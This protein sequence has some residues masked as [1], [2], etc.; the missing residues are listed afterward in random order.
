[1]NRKESYLIFI[2]FI[3]IILNFSTCNNLENSLDTEVKLDNL[4]AK[5]EDLKK[6]L[7]ILKNKLAKKE[8]EYKEE[9]NRHFEKTSELE[10]QNK[11]L[12]KTNQNLKGELSELKYLINKEI[13]NNLK[14]I[15]IIEKNKN[16]IESIIKPKY[17]LNIYNPLTLK[18]D[19]IVAGLTVEEKVIQT[20]EDINMCTYERIIFNGEFQLKGKLYKRD[21]NVEIVI[22]KS[23]YKNV[24]LKFEDL[25]KNKKYI[26]IANGEKLIKEIGDRYKEGILITAKYSGYLY[27]GKIESENIKKT[28]YIE[29]LSIKE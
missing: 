9:F 12:S 20:L 24:P 15:N 17:I 4:K 19:Q 28:N 11:I 18:K 10:K 8:T 6:E 26:V 3:I 16:E 7:C 23:Q 14:Y 25:E 22:D 13:N 1:M 27:E 5:N 2:I 29:L 21:S